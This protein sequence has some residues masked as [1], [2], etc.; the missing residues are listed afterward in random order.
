MAHATELTVTTGR[1]H[2]SGDPK[3]SER[4]LS[5]EVRVSVTYHLEPGDPDVPL[6]AAVKA[7]EA[8]RALDAACQAAQARCQE[9]R[10]QEGESPPMSANGSSATNG[11][12]V[13][14]Q[15]GQAQQLCQPHSNGGGSDKSGQYGGGNTG[16]GPGS[17]PNGQA[18]AASQ[19]PAPHASVPPSARPTRTASRSKRSATPVSAAGA[20]AVC[21]PPAGDGIGSTQQITPPQRLAIRSLCARLEVQDLEL[22]LLLDERFGKRNLEDLNKQEAGALLI[23]LQRGEWEDEAGQPALA[24]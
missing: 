4:I 7:A 23:A 18:P 15:H 13:P 9:P 20:S 17:Y 6:L 12:A 2:Y 1:T 11:T 24:N 21:A 8:E 14:P 10:E 16:N 3:N 22:K 19:P 5:R